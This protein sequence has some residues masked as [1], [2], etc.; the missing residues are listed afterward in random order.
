MADKRT[1]ADRAETIKRAVSK[2]RR[3]LKEMAIESFGGACQMCGYNR[4]IEALQFHHKDPS[5]KEFGLA[6]SGLTRSWAR[7]QR[8]IEKCILVCSNC[9]A[10]I[11]AGLRS[12]HQK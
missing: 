8:E 11:H 10:E 4:C 6:K 3:R 12:P 2:R 1:Y 5:Q 7:V 9:H